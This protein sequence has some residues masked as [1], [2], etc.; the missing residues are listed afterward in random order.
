MSELAWKT[1]FEIELLAPPGK[2]R[3]DLAAAIGKGF[4]DQSN[5][6]RRIF[7]PQSEPSKVDGT[8][9]FENL[10]LGYEVY[11]AS[12]T[13]VAKCVD[14]LTIRKNLSRE[15]KSQKG[16]YRIISDDKRLLNLVLEHCDPEADQKDVLQP[17]AKLFATSVQKLEGDIYHVADRTNASIAMAPTLPGE[18]HRPCE[19]IS[20]PLVTGQLSWL[21][22]TLSAAHALG[23][24]AP[25]EAAVHIHFDATSLRKAAVFSRLVD[26]L[27]LHGRSLRNLVE[28]NTNCTRLGELPNELFELMARPGIAKSSWKPLRDQLTKIKLTKFCDFNLMNVVLDVPD[29]QTFEVRIFPGSMDAKEIF[30]WARLFEAI[31][32]NCVEHTSK[33]PSADFKTFLMHLQL[34]KSEQEHWMAEVN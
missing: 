23:F 6:V 4:S 3:R 25:T 32:N 15:A 12:N 8:P 11:D 2:S 28:T 20:P 7:Y 24:A 5:T 1:G 31:L 22:D 26:V 33:A 19:L 27:R 14:D 17:L 29:K 21:Q 34:N 16:W 10:V 9:V 30:N 18:R 13:L